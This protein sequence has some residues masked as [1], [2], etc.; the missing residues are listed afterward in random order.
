MAILSEFVASGAPGNPYTQPAFAIWSNQGASYG[1][2]SFIDHNLNTIQRHM[3]S[4]GTNAETSMSSTSAPEMFDTWSGSDYTRTSS[5][6]QSNANYTNSQ[7]AGYL[8]H[9]SFN[10]GAYNFGECGIEMIGGTAYSSYRATGMRDCC[11]IVNDIDQ[12]YAIWVNSTIFKIGPRSL[13]YYAFH[14]YSV[15]GQN[16]SVT[17]KNAG[18]SNTRYGTGSYNAKTNKFCM[19][20]SNAGYAMKPV[21]YSNVPNLRYYSQ[22]M[23]RGVTESLTAQTANTTGALYTHFNTVSNYTTSYAAASGKPRNNGI[24]DNYRCITVMCDNDKVVMYQMIP[25]GNPNAWVTRWAANGTSEGS[26]KTY[27]GT[28]SYGYDQG[29]RFGARW[30]VTTDGR[31]IIAYSPYYYY[32]CGSH[33]AI[34]RVSDGKFIWDQNNDTTY[35]YYFSPVGVSDFAMM[36]N[37]NADGGAG[38]YMQSINCDHLFASTADAAQ[39]NITR[40]YISQNLS[41]N[42]NSTDYPLLIPLQ[43]DNRAFLTAT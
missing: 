27:G 16:I 32:G 12:D 2:V 38:L 31:Y 23:Y 17:T 34:I 43:Y 13:D 40:A 9:I 3:Y 24:E 42:Y 33:C 25:N 19:M 5:P 37:I 21:I 4:N 35:S 18:Y 7:F 6:A 41:G 22:N 28:T 36:I 1:G 10:S 20:E 15:T 26:L 39:A 29:D 14:N 8:G 11:T 30:H